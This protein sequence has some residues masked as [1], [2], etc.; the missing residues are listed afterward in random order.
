M[1]SLTTKA[2]RADARTQ[3][4]PFSA[5][6]RSEWIKL[7][8]LP[9][10]FLAL[11]GILAIGLGGS[12][13]LALTLE[14]SGVPSVPSI[15]RTIGEVTIAMVVVGQIIAGI[16]GVMSIGAEYSSGA[17]QST[18]LASPTR[19]RAL[20]AKAIVAFGVVT[21]VALV[22]VFG[23]WA[24]TYP[25]YARFGLDAPLGA[26]GVLPALLGAA[27]YLGLCAAFGVGLGAVVRSTTAGAIIVFVVTLLGPVLTSVLPY[28]L[29]S[30]VLRVMLLG[31]AGDAMARVAPEGAPFLDVWGGHI[32]AEA[33][34]LFVCLWVAAALTAGAVALTKR[35]A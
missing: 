33:G 5:T 7:T 24:A 21:V 1:M 25:L 12:L 13:F 23:S 18:L 14:S 31:N 9:S 8:S 28:S 4:P 17:I 19:L 30:R 15:E 22:T 34:G 35:D 27:A 16:L 11:G 29:F 6:L 2:H 20:W 3:R 32:S 10:S 26:P